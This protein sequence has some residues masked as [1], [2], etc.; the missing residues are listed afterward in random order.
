MAQRIGSDGGASKTS[1][2][3]TGRLSG[4]GPRLGD[5]LRALRLSA[6]LTQSDL[7][8]ER[9]SKEYISQIERGKTRPRQDT[10]VWLA[11]RLG[12][13]AGYL[14]SGVSSDERAKAEA[15][16]ARADTLV[17][18]T[19]FGDAVAEFRRALPAVLAT[20]SDELRVRL[21]A[22]EGTALTRDGQAR[23]ALELLDQARV[24][25]EDDRFSDVDRADI[26]LRLGV[27]RYQLS[28]I[29]TA[30]ALFGEALTLAERSGL[31]CDRLRLNIFGWR[32]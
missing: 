25:V 10:V 28:S 12:V 18:E 22:G 15:M 4:H 11:A 9:F 23:A 7:A 16:L 1:R 29:S 3:G 17:E 19:R 13:D 27:C 5:R 24:L 30:I 21:L 26:L 32:R 8:G 2:S 14:L 6:G 31:P 20:G